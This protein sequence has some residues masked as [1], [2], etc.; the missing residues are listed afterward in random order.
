[1]LE[2]VLKYKWFIGMGLGI[3]G[4]LYFGIILIIEWYFDKFIA[5]KYDESVEN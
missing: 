1:M 5:P 2:M 3:F 4:I